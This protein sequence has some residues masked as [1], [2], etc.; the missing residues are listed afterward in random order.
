MPWLRHADHNLLI[1][2]CMKASSPW[3]LLAR[4]NIFR[5]QICAFPS[6]RSWYR[7]AHQS[8]WHRLESRRRKNGYN[9][10]QKF[11]SFD[12]ALSLSLVVWYKSVKSENLQGCNSD[13]TNLNQS[14]QLTTA[15]NIWKA[16]ILSGS[17]V[18]YHC[19]IVNWILRYGGTLNRY[20]SQ[21]HQ[22]CLV[23]GSWLSRKLLRNRPFTYVP[24]DYLQFYRGHLVRWL[25]T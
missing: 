19:K 22:S 1:T 18:K 13:W 12:A 8:P 3:L 14:F 2:L 16:D 21:R 6:F 5:G 20:V 11:C 7:L 4:N 15:C 10:C 25:D 17:R 9:I 23:Q 24:G